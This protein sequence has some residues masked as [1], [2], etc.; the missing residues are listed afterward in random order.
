MH[1]PTWQTSGVGSRRN[2][3]R[4]AL[5]RIARSLECPVET[6]MQAAHLETFPDE[7]AELVRLWFKIEDPA[8]RRAL[9]AEV[10]RAAMR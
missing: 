2:R 4:D 7:T 8:V 10:R 3:G 6:L 9:L 5:Q 1:H